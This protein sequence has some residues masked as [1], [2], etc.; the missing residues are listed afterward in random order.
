MAVWLRR[1][2]NLEQNEA[3]ESNESNGIVAFCFDLESSEF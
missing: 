3:E 2:S 1:G